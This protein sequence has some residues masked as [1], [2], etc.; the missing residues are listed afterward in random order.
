MKI[1]NQCIRMLVL[2]VLTV[3][4]CQLEQLFPGKVA[5]GVARLTVRNAGNIVKLITADTVCGFSSELV[6]TTRLSEGELGKVGKI[7]ETV[8]NCQLTFPDEISLGKDCNGVDTRVRGSFTVSAVRTL[9]G[10]LTGSLD[11]PA[12]P[13]S[14]EPM[15]M[16]LTVVFDNFWLGNN[17]NSLTQKSGQMTFTA[18][19]HVAVSKTLGLCAVP[20]MDL[21]LEKIAYQNA[22]LRAL[23]DGSEFDVDVPSSLL[24]AQVGAW[25]D[26]ENALSGKIV[27]WDS[28][29]SVPN[30]GLGLDP[31]YS[32]QTF[33]DGYTCG[34]VTPDLALPVSYECPALTPRIAEGF[35]PLALQAFGQFID[36]VDLDVECG[37][38]SPSILNNPMVEGTLGERGGKATWTI[39]QPCT[40]VWEEPTLIDEDCLGVQTWAQGTITAKGSKSLTGYVTGDPAQP[41]VPD[42]WTPAEVQMEINF[43]NASIWTTTVDRT[44]TI[45]SGQLSGTI[46]PRTEMDAELGVCALKIP[47]V[48]FTDIRMDKMDATI[49]NEGVSLSAFVS[50]GLLNAQA[51]K[52]GN[53]ENWLVGQLMIDDQEVNLPLQGKEPI[54]NPDYD[55][56]THYDAFSCKPNFAVVESSE[57]CDFSKGLAENTSRLIIQTLGHIA[58]MVNAS[59]DGGF[60]DMGV[61]LIPEEAE[62]DA[63][64]MGMLTHATERCVVGALEEERVFDTDCV[65]TDSIVDGTA[66]VIASRTVT[67]L[68]DDIIDLSFL[69]P[70]LGLFD[71]NDALKSITPASHEAVTIDIQSAI[72]ED[73]VSYTLP[74]GDTEPV[75]SFTIESGE[76]KGTVRPIMQQRVGSPGTYDI[77]TPAAYVEDV[78]VFNLKGVLLGQGKIFNVEIEYAYLT[79]KNGIFQGEGNTVNGRVKVNGKMVELDEDTV[80]NPDFDQDA[81]NQSY[82]CEEGL[83]GFIQ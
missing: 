70:L 79:A 58:S 8:T 71:A 39:E 61:L 3:S 22:E 60:E 40:I 46:A 24:E 52:H 16:E 1:N 33:I 74:L 44:F 67:G 19:P 10:V 14:P 17:E 73:Y 69:D 66:T 68:R 76:M 81:F 48:T 28:D 75:G 12:L 35:A 62:G 54:F 32:A 45:T 31:E 15:V 42:S 77:A 18:K 59:N 55:P 20:T 23:S 30:D 2:C 64:E 34:D 78:E 41:I 36:E 5:D 56:A 80:L 47:T 11:T 26:K 50:E 21:T 25:G 57:D 6:Q 53:L 63:G 72:L 29:Q 4:S 82:A 7:T 9:E 49:E 43:D 51:G 13:L 65:Q 83:S 37:F 27:V 38:S